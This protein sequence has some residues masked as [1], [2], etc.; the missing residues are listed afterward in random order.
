MRIVPK[1]GRIVDGEITLYRRVK[2]NDSFSMV[3]P[4]KLTDLDRQGREMRSIRGSEISMIFQEP[5]SCFSPVYTIG[6]QVMEAVLLH[7]DVTEKEA[8][9]QVIEMMAHVGIPN[10]R[11]NFDSYPHQ[12]SGGMRQRA[13]IALALMCRPSLVI[14]DEPTTAVDVT[15][16]AQVLRLMREL[17][18]EFGMAI[19]F[20]THDLGVIA[21][22]AEEVVVMY[23]GKIVESAD[24]DTIFHNPKHPYLRS[25]L[26]S[27][28]RIGAKTGK[29][30]GS[31][32]GM[33]PDPFNIPPGCPFHT[34]CPEF[35]QGLCDVS[36]P[37][38]GAVDDGHRV[39]CHLY[40]SE[41]VQESDRVED[42]EPKL[43]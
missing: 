39:S 37:V 23:M 24:V 33:V 12:L 25:L 43:A 26:K 34:R 38:Y 36:D 29:R 7:R 6:D 31:I 27:I 13:M 9:E 42:K 16:E 19:M 8:R 1:P 22:M 5:M 11:Q 41:M 14:A 32:K 40:T 18:D 28:P 3:E 20:I 15:T 4:V 10:A 17:Q 30:L 35:V 2:S 21:Q